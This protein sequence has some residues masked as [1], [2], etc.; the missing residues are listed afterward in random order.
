[1]RDARSQRIWTRRALAL[2]VAAIALATAAPAEARRVFLV[3]IGN[4]TGL[5]AEGELRY[6]EQD[7][8]AVAG[9]LQRLG[10]VAAAETVL[11]L[12]EDVPAIR[13]TLLD[14]N[15]RVRTA[16]DD[17]ERDTAL[18]VYYSG[19]AD[20]TGL[21]LGGST[22]PFEEL[23]AVVAGSPATVRVLVLDA[24]RSGG[25]TQVKGAAP[26][27]EF[28]IRMEDR[29]AVEGL[30]II[31]SS[32][33]GEDSHESERLRASFFSHHLVSGLR[34]AADR[35]GD[36][37]VTLHEAYRW[38]YA[39]T[40]RSSGQT[41]SLQHPTFR[42]D[43]KG[44]GEFVLTEVLDAQRRAARLTL[45][46]AG[47]YLVMEGSEGGPV[48]AEVMAE[49]RDARL[50]LPPGSYFVQRRARDHYREYRVTLE[51]GEARD[52]ASERY[53]T[54]AYARLVRKGGSAKTASHAL[55]ALGGVRGEILSGHG[56][57][58]HVA[59]GYTLDLP[60]FSVG[61]RGRFAWSGAT[62]DGGATKSR[63]WEIGLGLA[64][65]RYFDVSI[66]SFSFGLLV[67]AVHWRQTFETAGVATDRAS[68]GLGFGGLLGIEVEV[69]P[70]LVLRAE[71][72]PMTYVQRRGVTRGGAQVSDDLATPLTGWGALGLGW[73]F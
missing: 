58:P 33:A 19:H 32:A 53:R 69:T 15:L 13:R 62:A 18:V 36:G 63:L 49:E 1:M 26:A 51:R 38:A 48:V 41:T 22:L 10:G 71:G 43:I 16:M 3:A 14:M 24:C 57:T 68:W 65:H 21:H 72:G 9:V 40:L 42:Y 52:L 5:P 55:H 7:A 34:G 45:P 11:A 66:V 37:R 23:K 25:A 6:A 39:Q 47:L 46:G 31:T 50:V 2:L 28:S 61:L 44:R 35:N 27:P 30:A 70:G 56:V 29:Y 67:E 59:L 73:R 20:A 64:V 4:N 54:V 8:R 12:G 60:W 17:G